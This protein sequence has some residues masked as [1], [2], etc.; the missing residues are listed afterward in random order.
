VRPFPG[1]SYRFLGPRRRDYVA[2]GDPSSA[3]SSVDTPK[4]TRCSGRRESSQ[5]SAFED[6]GARSGYEAVEYKPLSAFIASYTAL[7]DKK[8][9]AYW[10]ICAQAYCNAEKIRLLCA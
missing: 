10:L 9:I 1:N 6:A 7:T 4:L 3:I 8:A 2:R 5:V